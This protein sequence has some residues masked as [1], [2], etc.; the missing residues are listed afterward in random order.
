MPKKSFRQDIF[1]LDVDIFSGVGYANERHRTYGRLLWWSG[2]AGAGCWF[3]AWRRTKMARARS[4]VSVSCYVARYDAPQ[5][6]ERRANWR[7]LGME[8]REM[9]KRLRHGTCWIMWRVSDAFEIMADWCE[10][11]ADWAEVLGGRIR[12]RD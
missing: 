6:V 8:T 3:N 10:R 2:K 12:G 4:A 1:S 9:I 7:H 11:A 5:E